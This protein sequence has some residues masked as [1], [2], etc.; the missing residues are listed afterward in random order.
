[1]NDDEVR[2]DALLIGAAHWGVPMDMLHDLTENLPV[3]HI[4]TVAENLSAL[5]SS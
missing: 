3:E 1:M 4:E 5:L 2:L